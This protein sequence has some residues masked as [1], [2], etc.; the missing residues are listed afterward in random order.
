MINIELAQT[1]MLM[2]QIRAWGVLE[3]KWLNVIETIDR[4]KFVPKTYRD[5]AYADMSIPLGYGQSMLS[6]C[7]EA[8]LL[9]ALDPKTH[10][11]ILEI[12]TGSGYF[13][14]LLAANG[15]KV[16]SVEIIP[17]LHQLAKQNLASFS[18][19]ELALGNGAFGWET[20]APYDAIIITGALPLLAETFLSQLKPSGRLIAIVGR[21][22]YAQQAIQCVKHKDGISQ[23]SLFTT[24][25]PYLLE[26]PSAETFVF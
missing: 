2:Q 22:K 21:D 12:G 26:G 19:I 8:R 25:I 13:T 9:Q 14:A 1:N 16:V 18:S 6:P 11:H 15:A 23:T 10:E 17:A 24:S 4:A 20:Q 5:F 3:E 7:N